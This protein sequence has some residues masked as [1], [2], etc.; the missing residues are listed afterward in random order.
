METQ[1][2]M[3]DF[4]IVYHPLNM[5]ILLSAKHFTLVVAGAKNSASSLCSFLLQHC[6]STVK[7]TYLYFSYD[8]IKV[9]KTLPY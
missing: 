8:I 1:G 7:K 5:F 3:V 9:V 6:I 4:S 2:D